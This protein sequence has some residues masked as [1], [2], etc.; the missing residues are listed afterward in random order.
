MFFKKWSKLKKT[1]HERSH[2]L[3]FNRIETSI[4]RIDI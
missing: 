2:D 1:S 3:Y 4:L